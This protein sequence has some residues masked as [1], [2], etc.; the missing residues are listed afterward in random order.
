MAPVVASPEGW[1]VSVPGLGWSG[2]GWMACRV[3]AVTVGVVM[4]VQE[5]VVM[6]HWVGAAGC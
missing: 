3:M 4:T 6:V 5:G 1:Q 2:D